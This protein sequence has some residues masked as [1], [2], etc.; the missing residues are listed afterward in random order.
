M[1]FT[2]VTLLIPWTLILDPL[3]L[4]SGRTRDLSTPV[5]FLVTS[6]VHPSPLKQGGVG[7]G[8]NRGS[9]SR[10]PLLQAPAEAHVVTFSMVLM[11]GCGAMDIS[12]SERVEP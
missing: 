7:D 11:A 2:H 4:E 6:I 8:G 12:T 10:P 3:S 1:L 5:A 9:L